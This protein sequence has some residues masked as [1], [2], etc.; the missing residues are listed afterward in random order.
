MCL[1]ITMMTAIVAFNDSTELIFFEI[2]EVEGTVSPWELK[3]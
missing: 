1:I 2:V 3:I